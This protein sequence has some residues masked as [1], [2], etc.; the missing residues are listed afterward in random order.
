MLYPDDMDQEE[1]DGPPVAV[2]GV[3]SELAAGGA[4]VSPNEM[5]RAVFETAPAAVVLLDSKE[6]ILVACD[7][8]TDRNPAPTN[9]TF[10]KEI[11]PKLES[12][13]LIKCASCVMYEFIG[14]ANMAHM[15]AEC[16]RNSCD[17]VAVFHVKDNE[18]CAFVRRR[19]IR[20]QMNI[21]GV[22][23]T[24]KYVLKKVAAHQHASMVVRAV[25]AMMTA[26]QTYMVNFDFLPAK[27]TTAQ[28]LYTDWGAYTVEQ[29]NF[30]ILDSLEKVRKKQKV[31]ER[32]VT[33]AKVV[34]E[35]MDSP[36]LFPEAVLEFIK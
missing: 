2:P 1:E 18:C 19:S 22:A 13:G 36:T 16:V 35:F 34:H 25:R 14:V 15:H 30:E 32:D 29:V 31:T 23:I 4:G 26:S 10:V 24:N 6:G 20:R 28:S 17:I 7:T 21:T 27:E 8:R 5:F 9:E 12:V 33:V 11:A 3:S